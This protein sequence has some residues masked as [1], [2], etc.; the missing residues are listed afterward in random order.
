MTDAPPRIASRPCTPSCRSSSARAD[1]F[2][3]VIGQIDMI[4]GQLATDQDFE[5][6]VTDLWLASED[7]SAFR[8]EMQALGDRLLAAKVAYLEAKALDDRLFGDTL[9][10]GARS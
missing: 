5:E 7:A 3:L 9:A 8:A 6:L 10:A 4:L 2:E 1:M